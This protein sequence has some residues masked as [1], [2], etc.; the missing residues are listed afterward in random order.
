MTLVILSMYDTCNGWVSMNFYF[1]SNK[2]EGRKTLIKDFKETFYWV[3]VDGERQRAYEGVPE[4]IVQTAMIHVENW[5]VYNRESKWDNY[6]KYIIEV[7]GN[8][9]YFSA[10]WGEDQYKTKL[11]NAKE[12][13]FNSMKSFW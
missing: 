4:D 7:Y 6:E 12:S 5:T 2:S 9:F 10:H 13:G 3:I 11:Y 1:P 8:G